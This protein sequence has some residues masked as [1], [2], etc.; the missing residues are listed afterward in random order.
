MLYL[1][2]HG[3]ALAKEQDPDRPLSDQGHREVQQMAA[4]LRDAGI[5][6]DRVWHSGKTR[7]KQTAEILA[8]AVS[9]CGAIETMSG[10]APN[11]PVE[12]LALQI[13]ELF[14]PIMIVGHLP[15]MA[16]LVG[17]LLVKQAEPALVSYQPGSIVCLQKNMEHGW[18][19][20]WMVRPHLFIRQQ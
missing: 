18:Q 11:D 20:T 1:V 6:V 7:A 16:R 19:I 12:P 3:E 14:T 2:Q 10:L 9:E 17:L 5:T 8:H 15:F 4:F 13:E